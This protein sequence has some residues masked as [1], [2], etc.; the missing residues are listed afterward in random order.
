MHAGLHQRALDES[1]T[2]FHLRV[3]ELK[4]QLEGASR[5][6]EQLRSDRT[7]HA[8]MVEAIVR[9]RD[10]YRVLLQQGGSAPVSFCVCV[11]VCGAFH[12]FDIL[13]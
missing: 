6:L 9:Q 11:C 8:E 13:S 3:M 2:G 12:L 1:P 4:Q 10:M 5:E 7:R